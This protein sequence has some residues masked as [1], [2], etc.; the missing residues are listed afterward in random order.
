MSGK[1]GRKPR[2]VTDESTEKTVVVEIPVADLVEGQYVNEHVDVHLDCVQ[3]VAM[4]RVYNGLLDG[5]HRM[6]NGH[7]V[8]SYV[9]A[10]RWLCEQIAEG[11]DGGT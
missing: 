6:R 4:R 9:D 7:H 2:T 8:R 11:I 10:V 3:R 5:G 1:M